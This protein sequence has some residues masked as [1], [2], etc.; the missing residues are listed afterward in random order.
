MLPKASCYRSTPF[1]TLRSLHAATNAP[2]DRLEMVIV[3]RVVSTRIQLLCEV[4]CLVLLEVALI[5]KPPTAHGAL[6]GCVW[7][8]QEF[9]SLETEMYFW[10]EELVDHQAETH[11]FFPRASIPVSISSANHLSN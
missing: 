11:R 4:T 1:V 9:L 3:M 6:D 10:S 5:P 2:C 7:F 8:C